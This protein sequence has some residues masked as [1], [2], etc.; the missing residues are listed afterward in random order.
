MSGYLALALSVGVLAV[1]D[2]WLYVGPLSSTI[3]AGL[4]WISFIA[5]GCHYHSGG[6]IKGTTTAVACMSWGAL[7]GM[8]AVML[9]S[10]PLGTAL[11]AEVGTA[12]AVGLGATLICLSSKVPLLATIPASVYGFASIAG[13]IILRGDAPEK[14]IMP[15]VASI[16]IGAVFGFVSEI[17]ANALT[18]KTPAA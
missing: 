17:V 4:V 18:K 9:A 5:W 6:G 12:V 11:G 2:T 10:G 13:P 16:I 15:V 14:A 7:V 3:L 1:L 8:G